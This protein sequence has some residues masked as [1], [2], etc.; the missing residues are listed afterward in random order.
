MK[1][2]GTIL[3][4]FLLVSN[5]SPCVLR[6]VD[7]V[8]AQRLI[9]NVK[10]SLQRGQAEISKLHRR[11]LG[12]HGMSSSKVRHF[13]NNIC[14]LPGTSYLEI[15]LHKGST[16]IAA[17]FNN[18]ASITQAI[19]ID[20]W[21]QFGGPRLDFIKN[22]GAFL[23]KNSFTLYE[24]DCFK[25]N[26]TLVFKNPVNI[27]FYDG[28][29]SAEAQ[30]LAFTYYNNIF[31]DVFIAIVDDFNYESVSTATRNVFKQLNYTVLFEN[32]LPSRFN[33]DKEN[34]WNGLYVAV[35]AKN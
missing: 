25:L 1:K 30:T 26:K 20:N 12:I 9:S 24:G 6:A 11:I 19:G 27:Y 3:L 14:S 2:V 5:C 4:F 17:L 16:F 29:H 28:D 13:L 21:S 35:V 8:K 31:D 33:G 23:P 22:A 34:W 18:Q 10:Q 15:G 7:E 32:I